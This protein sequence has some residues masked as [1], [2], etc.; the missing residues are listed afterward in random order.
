MRWFLLMLLLVAPS[1]AAGVRVEAVRKGNDVVF[2]AINEEAV[3]TTVWVEAELEHLEANPPL[4]LSLV[5]PAG[6]TVR[7]TTLHWR[8]PQ[9]GRYNYKHW[10]E[11]G[12]YRVKPDEAVT[13]RIPFHHGQSVHIVQ[14]YLGTFSHQDTYALDFECP[15]QTPV[16]A[17]RGGLVVAVIDQFTEGGADPSLKSKANLV[18]VM[19][20]D[21]SLADYVHLSPGGARV[22]VGQRVETGQLLGLSGATGYATSPH[23][24]FEVYRP[25]ADAR[26]RQSL[27]VKFNTAQ[28]AQKLEQ[29]ASYTVP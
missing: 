10:W 24:H 9:P 27:A 23:L 19:H 2:V 29:G 1:W 8:G 21:G 6:K 15:L 14:G 26:H 17:A 16:V 11:L 4:P 20:D 3:P 18:A 28:G 5:V 13:Y 25:T 22:K 7:V 12:D